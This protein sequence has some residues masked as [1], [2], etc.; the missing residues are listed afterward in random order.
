MSSALVDV[1]DEREQQIRDSIENFVLVSRA[2]SDNCG[3]HIPA[4]DSDEPRPLCNRAARRTHSPHSTHERTWKLKPTAV[5][6]PG[7]KDICAY[8]ATRWLDDE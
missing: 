5:Y 7:H 6:P 4:P 8:C 1:T 2:S 3:L